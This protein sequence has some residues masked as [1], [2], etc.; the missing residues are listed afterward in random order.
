VTTDVE[1]GGDSA[2]QQLGHREVDAG[3]RALEILRAIAHRQVL[4]QP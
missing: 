3:E 2:A 4:E 1:H